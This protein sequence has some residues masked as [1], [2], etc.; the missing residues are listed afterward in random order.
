MAE[1]D[2]IVTHPFILCLAPNFPVFQYKVPQQPD[3]AYELAR[4]AF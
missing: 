2:P 4:T 1:K 3:E